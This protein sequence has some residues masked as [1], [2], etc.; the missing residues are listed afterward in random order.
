MGVG[1]DR[2]DRTALAKR[3]VTVCNVPGI[4]PVFL[5]LLLSL[6]SPGHILSSLNLSPRRKLAYTDISSDYG[7]G[8]IADHALAL[9]L[10]LRRGILLHHDRQRQPFV[11]P[12][13]PIE[14]PLVSRIQSATFGIIGLGRIGTAVCLRAKAFGWNVIFYDPYVPNGIDKALGVERTKDINELFRRSTALSIHCTCTRETRNMIG[15]E[16]VSLMPKGSILVNT[17]RG[18]ILQLDALERGLKEGI[19]A[20]AGLDVLP[21]EPIP[22]DRVHP[23]IQAYRKQ[24]EWLVGRLTLTCHTAFYSPQSFIDI[25]V[26]SAQTMREVLIDGL[27]SNVVTPDML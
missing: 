8:E 17:A 10:G 20:G 18:E 13:M 14:T 27:Q 5:L 4:V 6:N 19:L 15:W 16:H 23:L 26:K 3:N 24:E 25:R 11:Y 21:E 9:I 1:Y 22:L 7:T 2:L 12:W